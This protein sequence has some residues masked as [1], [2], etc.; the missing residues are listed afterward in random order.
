DKNNNEVLPFEFDDIKLWNDS[1]A[2]VKSVDQWKFINL[3]N[4]QPVMEEI[5][6]IKF[7]EQANN[8]SIQRAIIYKNN[9][10]GVVTSHNL[11]FLSPVYDDI[12]ILGKAEN[13]IFFAEKRVKEAG[14]YV[15]IYYNALG[16][17]IHQQT[18]SEEQYDLIYCY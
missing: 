15:V 4:K 7:L 3:N 14:L 8:T 16:N 18:F 17:T 11:E 13:P 2:L 6:D 1:L 9:A 10:Y 12:Y 5:S